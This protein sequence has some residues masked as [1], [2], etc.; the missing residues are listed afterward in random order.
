MPS[1][2]IIQQESVVSVSTHSASFLLACIRLAWAASDRARSAHLAQRLGGHVRDFSIILVVELPV[3]LFPK[4]KNGICLSSVIC[5]PICHLYHLS[6]VSSI[7]NLFYQSS[8]F[9][10]TYP[11]ICLFNHLSTYLS[12]T[13]SVHHLSIL[14]WPSSFH[15]V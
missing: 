5:P 7:I 2:V 13:Q 14:L 8:V 3:P 6:I 11:V 15:K 4:V 10:S 12:Y 9:L 1:V